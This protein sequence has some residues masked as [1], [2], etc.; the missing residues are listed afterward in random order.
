MNCALHQKG[1]GSNVAALA[2][3]RVGDVGLHVDELGKCD[4]ICYCFGGRH[5]QLPAIGEK[6]LNS[7]FERVQ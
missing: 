2:D 5:G 3:E 4:D 6:L 7:S 1:R